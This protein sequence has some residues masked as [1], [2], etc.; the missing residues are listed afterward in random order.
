MGVGEVLGKERSERGRGKSETRGKIRGGIRSNQ[1]ALQQ[2]ALQQS[3][4]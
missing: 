1:L 2:F 4:P 3:D